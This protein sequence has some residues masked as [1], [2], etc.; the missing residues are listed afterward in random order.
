M[1]GK[2][3]VCGRSAPTGV[4]SSS[5]SLIKRLDIPLRCAGRGVVAGAGGGRDSE[6]HRAP[7]HPKPELPPFSLSIGGLGRERGGGSSS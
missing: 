6:E 4:A 5:G 2:P 3:A 1:S 7:P